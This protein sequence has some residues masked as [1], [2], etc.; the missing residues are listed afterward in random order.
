MAE[1]KPHPPLSL[2]DVGTVGVV[3]ILVISSVEKVF[4]SADN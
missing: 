2:T 3:V 1:E 4:L